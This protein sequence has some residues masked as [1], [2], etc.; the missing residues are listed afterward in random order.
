[1]ART[2]SIGSS[3]WKW[4]KKSKKYGRRSMNLPEFDASANSS[5]PIRITSNSPMLPKV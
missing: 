5:A 4:M 1:M 3:G 2:T